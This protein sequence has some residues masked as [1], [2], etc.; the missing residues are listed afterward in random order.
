M[1]DYIDK[2]QVEFAPE[3]PVNKSRTFYLLHHVVKQQKNQ[4]VKYRTV[5]DVSSHSPG[6]PSLDE[7]L[8]KGP[9]LLPEIL[10]TLLC[11]RLHKQAIICNGSQVFQQLTLREEDRDATRFLWFRIEKN[12][13]EK[14]HL[15]NDILIYRF[16]RLPFGLS[17]SPFLLSAS[18]SQN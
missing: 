13:D 12:A 17:L 8:E 16:S 1:Q 6:H 4:N 10:A 15:L 3:T 7:V 5:F 14:T 2:N 11:F 9:N 18:L